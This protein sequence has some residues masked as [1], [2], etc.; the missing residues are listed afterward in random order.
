MKIELEL[1]RMYGE[2]ELKEI[3]EFSKFLVSFIKMKREHWA[4]IEKSKV[5]FKAK[6][7]STK[8][9]TLPKSKSTL[10]IGNVITNNK[11]LDG[12]EADLEFLEEEE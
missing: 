11:H 12:D 10:V 1:S 7:K 5:E 3:E 4:E 8:K 9:K 6:T 2:D